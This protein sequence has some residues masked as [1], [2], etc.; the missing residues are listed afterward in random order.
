MNIK[1]NSAQHD[2][3]GGGERGSNLLVVIW[4]FPSLLSTFGNLIPRG[5]GREEGGEGRKGRKV[6][7]YL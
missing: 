4:S 2:G 5:K 3:G 1:H 6:W 7:S